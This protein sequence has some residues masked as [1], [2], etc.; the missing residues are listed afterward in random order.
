MNTRTLFFLF[1]AIVAMSHL[2][3]DWVRMEDPGGLVWKAAGIV[4]LGLYALWMRAWIAGLGLLFCAAGDVLLEIV[5]VA[6]MGAFA[7]GHLFYIFAFLE[8]GRVMGLN[9]RDVP[10]AVI[11]ALISLGLM[12]WFY[13]GMGDL[14]VP[15]LLYQVII[16]V[17]VA[18][19]F[20]VKAP[21]LARLGAV[22][23][24]ISDTLIA[25]GLFTDLKAP[26]GSVWITYAGAQIMIAW[27]MSRIAPFRDRTRRE[28]LKAAA[29]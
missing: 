18:T 6:G 21:M 13:P 16:T 22:L 9:R 17:M 12:A 2:A 14:L 27:G 28:A 24:M 15:A 10:M 20:T 19:A 23:F 5:F 8:W 11:V 4:L 29:A 26:P 3:N 25:L 1:A 7:V